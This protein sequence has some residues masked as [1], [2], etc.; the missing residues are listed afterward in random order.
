MELLNTNIEYGFELKG[1]N[2]LNLF[3][4]DSLLFMSAIFSGGM[5]C[6]SCKNRM[7]SLAVDNKLVSCHSLVFQLN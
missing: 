3:A 7:A 6:S 1:I 5:R 2:Y 4:H